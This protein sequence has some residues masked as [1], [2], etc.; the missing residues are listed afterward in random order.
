VSH[1]VVLIDRSKHRHKAELPQVKARKDVVS[2]ASRKGVESWLKG[3]QNCT[4]YEGHARF[5]SPTEVSVGTALLTAKRIFIKPPRGFFQ[6]HTFL[7]NCMFFE[8]EP[9]FRQQVRLE[10]GPFAR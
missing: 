8:G 10:L 7:A 9:I 2:S 6:F 1:G 3:M 5:V 4:V